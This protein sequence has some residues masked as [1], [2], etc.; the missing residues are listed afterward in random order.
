MRPLTAPERPISH[1]RAGRLR[2]RAAPGRWEWLAGHRAPAEAPADDVAADEA[3]QPEVREAAVPRARRMRPAAGPRDP[4]PSRWAYRMERLWLTP[5]FRGLMR[6]GLPMLVVAL[7]VG[8][9][10]G[11][12]DRRA[13]I[14]TRIADLRSQI[15]NRPE[16]MVK[17]MSIDGASAP[18]ADAIRAMLPVNLPASSFTLDLDGLRR[19]IEGVDAVQTATVQVRTGGVLAVI[20][21]ERKPAILWRTANSLEM[22]D[23]TGHRVA[24]LLDRA[25]RADMP[26]IAGAGAEN[27]VPEALAILA[28][29]RPILARIR[30]LERIGERRWDIV[31]DRDQRILLPEEN[32]VQAVEQAV[33]VDSAEDMLSRDLAVVDL[34]NAAR[35]TLRL[36]ENAVAEMRKLNETPTKV[37]GQ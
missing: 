36:T 18:V 24:T 35:P 32:P 10:F 5:L 22:L 23:A 29:A 17:L 9:Y 28:A 21:V 37:P 15:E 16:F 14:V 25:A 11:N 19:A 4:S 1:Y 26:V 20:V 12:A 27:A 33:A 7:A 31:L 3:P 30:G 2:S 13:A 34:R 6:Y 8:L